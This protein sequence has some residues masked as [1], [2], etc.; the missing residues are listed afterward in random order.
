MIKLA[1]FNE[2]AFVKQPIHLDP[3]ETALL[4]CCV[5]L[6]TMQ[7]RPSTLKYMTEMQLWIPT[8]MKLNRK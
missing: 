5:T 1:C 6:F 8:T 7:A 2:N 3:S 4:R